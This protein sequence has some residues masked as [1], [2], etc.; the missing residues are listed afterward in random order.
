MKN[1]LVSFKNGDKLQDKVLIQPFVR[2]YILEISK[3]PQ[4]M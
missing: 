2:Y 1:I 4:E 3:N